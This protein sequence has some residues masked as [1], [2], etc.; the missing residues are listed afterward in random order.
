M[1]VAPR[2]TSSLSE[3]CFMLGIN[4]M[5]AFECAPTRLV[6]SP[7]SQPVLENSQR[8]GQQLICWAR[9][10]F[11]FLAFGETQGEKC[12]RT[13]QPCDCRPVV[14]R[15]LRPAPLHSSH[16]DGES[17]REA[18]QIEWGISEVGSGTQNLILRSMVLLKGLL[19]VAFMIRSNFSCSEVLMTEIIFKLCL[20]QQRSLNFH[21]A[22]GR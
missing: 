6:S 4:L 21:T 13:S 8:D 1:L 15:Q 2:M 11:S 10:F 14:V 16:K 5:T 12:W 3:Q 7:M 22:T 20:F 17:A 19:N 18:E 9:F